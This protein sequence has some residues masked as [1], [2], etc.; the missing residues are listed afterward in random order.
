MSS[1]SKRDLGSKKIADFSKN[2]RKRLKR[3]DRVEI[4]GQL[5]FD[6]YI[7]QGFLTEEECDG[8]VA[9]IDSDAHPSTLYAGTEQE[10]FRTSYSCNLDPFHPLVMRVERR[11]SDL[12]GID[13]RH[14]ETLQGQRYLPGQQFK[15][16]NDYF[17]TNQSYWEAE[18]LQ[19]GQRTWTAMTYLNE[20]ES[21][22]E[23]NFPQVGLCVAPRKAMLVIWNNMD[24]VGAPNPLSLHEG[25]PVGGGTKH[26]TTKW[27]RERFWAVK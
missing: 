14:G 18:R 19:G 12:M 16:H 9:L 15:P 13:P 5:G 4:V 22:G 8:L 7:V 10:G 27:F 26:I 23:T 1:A 24:D 11:I 17:H 20:P 6:L 25:C 2:V 21:G 3:H